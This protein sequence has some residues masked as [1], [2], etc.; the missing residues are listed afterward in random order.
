MKSIRPIFSAL[1]ATAVLI[2]A[3]AEP[4]TSTISFSD[5]AKPGRLEIRVARGDV[6]IQGAD[7]AAVTVKSET[8]P[9][10]NA[11]RKD[12]LRVISATTSFSLTEKGNLIEL[13]ATA[14]GWGG[15]GRADFNL[16]VPRGTTVVVQNSWGGDITCTGLSGNLEINSMNGEVRLDEI[17]GGAVVSTMN[18]EIRANIREL[19]KGSPLS[20]TSMNGEVVLRVPAE[21]GANVRLRTQ[22]GS[23]LTDFDEKA[24]TTKTESIARTR[25]SSDRG[26]RGL[27]EDVQ[28]RIRHATQVSVTA[29]REAITAVKEGFEAARERGERSAQAAEAARLEAAQAGENK[30]S[31]P[32]APAAPKPPRAPKVY[33]PTISGGKLVTGE[34]NGGGAEISVSTMNGDVTLRKLDPKQ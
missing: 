21:A 29:V 19:R 22:N 11:P 9:A 33:I 1:V 18:G 25:G 4:T 12:G 8:K 17:S 6:R 14:D 20:F 5:P 2:T 10:T 28:E 24:L 3:R 34:L 32:A 23:V 16:T 27:P 7:T 26:N 13:D 15:K 31:S 30:I